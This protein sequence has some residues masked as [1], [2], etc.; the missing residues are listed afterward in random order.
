MSLN[1]F[2]FIMI[3][4]GVLMFCTGVAMT[5]RRRPPGDRP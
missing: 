3:G 2:D 4:V 1:V 5:L